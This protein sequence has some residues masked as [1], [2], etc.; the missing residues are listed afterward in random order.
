MEILFV[1]RSNKRNKHK[2]ATI[3]CRIT[4]NGKR[5]PAFSTFIKTTTYEWDSKAQKIISSRSGT[6]QD[7]DTLDNIRN[8]LKDI[9]NEL[10]RRQ[11]PIT[12]NIIHQLYKKEE[13]PSVTF[14]E[15][16]E[17]LIERKKER[18]LADG[19]IEHNTYKFNNTKYFLQSIGRTDL[20]ADEWNENLAYE[21]EDYLFKELKQCSNNHAAR[22]IQLI[23]AVLK[24]A[25]RKRYIQINPLLYFELNFDKPKYPVYLTEYEL[26]KL[27]YHTFSSSALQ[28]VA[29]IYI[30]CC[31]TGFAYSDY[32]NF[33][34]DEHLQKEYGLDFIMKDREKTKETAILPFYEK[35]RKILSKYNG[36]LPKI[37]NQPYNR[38]IKE[39]VA[40]L[41]IRKHITT[42]T[43]RKT[44]AM[45]WLNGGVPEETVAR[46]LGQNSTRQLKIYARVS[47]KK[48]A[49]DTKV[50]NK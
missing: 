42:H 11:K 5:A 7:N 19:T 6:D 17:Q 27:E 23:K 43:A 8:S 45:M 38:L 35:A 4:V 15:I 50:L 31:Y 26:A 2:P 3:Y 44:A 41:D 37:E 22:H 39:V 47:T 20:L 40:I 33:H 25:V 46:M 10:I 21:F 14:L 12:A 28:K 49:E 30:F 24:L 36:Q 18:K 48:I 1:L 9:Y 29:D 32:I 13:R 16:F 34:P